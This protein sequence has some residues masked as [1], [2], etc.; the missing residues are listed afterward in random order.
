[1]DNPQQKISEKDLYWL[2]GLFDGEGSCNI[3]WNNGYERKKIGSQLSPIVKL[4]NSDELI[5]GKAVGIL[6]ELKIPHHI[7]SKGAE[8]RNPA[9]KPA[10]DINVRGMKRCLRVIPY[11]YPYVYGEKKQKLEYV[12][13]FCNRRLRL[14]HRT[15]YSRS[16]F[17]LANKTR[18]S[19]LSSETIENYLNS[20]ENRRDHGRKIRN[21]IMV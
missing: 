10:W 1:M 19:E 3:T 12:L 20:L 5:I 21:E 7:I 18:I 11:L 2:G 13:T 6:K 15:P 8:K 17:I 4:T 16:D 14:P 9:W